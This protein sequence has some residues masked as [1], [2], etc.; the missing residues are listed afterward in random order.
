MHVLVAVFDLTGRRVRKLVDEDRSAGLQ[1]LRWDST[2]GGGPLPDGIYSLALQA[3]GVTRAR[4]LVL[5]R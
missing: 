1:Q 3:E 5:I 2:R 4:P